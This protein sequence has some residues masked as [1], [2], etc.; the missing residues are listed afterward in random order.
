MSAFGSMFPGQRIRHEA[1]EA[2]DGEQFLSFGPIDLES[3]T[4]TLQTTT[5]PRD[6]DDEPLDDGS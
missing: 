6:P 2:G 4:V 5:A 1:G 3:G